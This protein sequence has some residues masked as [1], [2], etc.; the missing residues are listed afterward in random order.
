V[1]VAPLEAITRVRMAEWSEKFGK[2]LGL[3]VVELTGGS[4]GW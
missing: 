4:V 1:Y 2:G 3:T